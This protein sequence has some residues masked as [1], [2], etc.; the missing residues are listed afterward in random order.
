MQE[1]YRT[2][3]MLLREAFHRPAAPASQRWDS[4]FT[5]ESF[6]W[7]YNQVHLNC[8]MILPASPWNVYASNLSRV[9]PEENR[10]RAVAA[11]L[12]INSR[13]TRLLLGD[14]SVATST[15]S[16]ASSPL[17]PHLLSRSAGSGLFTLHSKMNHCCEPNAISDTHRTLQARLSAVAKRPIRAGE[18]IT[19]DYVGF[20]RPG[21]AKLPSER[22]KV[23]R[24]AYDFAC[25]CKDP[26]CSCVA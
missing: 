2:F 1:M 25:S 8:S 24:E 18:E 22:Q 10:R 4:L 5:P 6:V 20:H 19:I 26:T 3:P 13:A 11:L 9:K 16:D 7:L 12:E 15:A 23:L 21:A 17:V 14:S